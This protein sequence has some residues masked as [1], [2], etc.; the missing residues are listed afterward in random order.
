[1]ST[2][3]KLH[4]REINARRHFFLLLSFLLFVPN[5]QAQLDIRSRTGL[6]QSSLRRPLPAEEAFPFFTTRLNL[7]TIELIFVPADTH[8]LYQHRFSFSL[9]P[10][11]SDKTA[12]LEAILP[13]GVSKTDEFFGSVKVYYDEVKILITLPTT[14]EKKSEILIEYQGCTDWGFCYPTRLRAIPL[15]AL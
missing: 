10:P 2:I 5:S 14:F 1:M 11:E 12:P 9:K 8:Y 3:F 7:E 13:V 15:H 4:K 6:S